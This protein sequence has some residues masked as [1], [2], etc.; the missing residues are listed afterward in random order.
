[1]PALRYD[2]PDG[3]CPL[4]IG[5]RHEP[6]LGGATRAIVEPATGTELGTVAEAGPEDVAL[7]VERA[8]AA[9]DGWAAIS[10]LERGRVLRRAGDLI[11]ERA[12][13][14]ARLEARNVGKPIREARGEVAFAAMLMDFFAGLAN[15]R[16]GEVVPVAAPGLDV[17]LREPVGVCG[18]IAPWNFPLMIAVAKVAPALA[19]GNPVVLK[20]AEATPVTALALAELLH[21]AGLPDGCLSVV[22]GAGETVG[23]ALVRDPRV[24]KISFTG[25]T[26]VGVRILQLAAPKVGRVTL[27]LGGKASC[28]VF[29]DADLERCAAAAI[30]AVFGNAG[31]DCCARSRLLVHEQVVDDFTAALVR[32]MAQIVVGDPLDEDTTMGP[33][34]SEAHR[35]RVLEYVEGALEQGASVLYGGAALE[36]DTPLFGAYMQPTLLGGVESSMRAAQEEIF[37]PVAMIIPFSDEDEAVALANDVDYGLAGSIWTADLG[38]ALR[39]MRRVRAG[40]LSVNS[41]QALHLEAPFGGV[42]RSGLGRELGI[43]ALDAYTETK[44]VYLDW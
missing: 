11:S 30:G 36:L 40:A 29:P 12:E 15:K 33:L 16:N 35:E 17:V 14:L 18:A 43:Q 42:G 31:Q 26:E 1:M 9:S 44:N 32:A 28:L 22:T 20:P 39:V 37:G 3:A 5:G 21:E 7:A 4:W 27:E 41:N 13:E 8:V 10:A 6:A 34:I 19:A 23:E 2:I 24:A 25:S 38:R